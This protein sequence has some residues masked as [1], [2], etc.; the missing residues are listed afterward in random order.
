MRKSTMVLLAALAASGGSAFW[1]QDQLSAERDANAALRQ[2][3]AAVAE[4]PKSVSAPAAPIPPQAQSPARATKVIAELRPP[5][6]PAPQQYDFSAQQRELMKNPEYRKAMRDQR[7]QYF[8]DVYG[9]LGKVLKLT[10]AQTSA[11]CDL[12]AD[13][14][15]E[16]SDLQWQQ[17][18]SKEDTVAL[19]RAIEEQERK[20]DQQLDRM[21]GSSSLSHLKEFQQ[22]LGSRMEVNRLRGELAMGVEALR[23]DQYQL[24]LDI[25]SAEQQRRNRELQDAFAADPTSGGT[26]DPSVRTRF[27]VAANERIV[28]SARSILTSAQLAIIENVY[29]RERQ[30]METQDS[31]AKVQFEAERAARDTGGN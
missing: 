7:R 1:L 13:Q 12:M 22:S 10:P 17:P 29:R 19:R 21:L 20:A 2:R 5:S 6:S 27:A 30:Q 8:E 4:S 25:V 14:S 23:D 15:I 28:D 16:L 11:L 31:M 3:L 18:A 26:F 9:E 24:M